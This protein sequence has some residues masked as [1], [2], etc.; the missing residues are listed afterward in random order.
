MRINIYRIISL[1]YYVIAA[2]I[3]MLYD[4]IMIGIQFREMD[5]CVFI[6]IKFSNYPV[7]CYYAEF[8]LNNNQLFQCSGNLHFITFSKSLSGTSSI[9]FIRCLTIAIG[10]SFR[11][12]I[13][14]GTPNVR[15]GSLS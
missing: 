10:S 14:N 3:L 13:K 9:S 12:F 7:V 2:K 4:T 11:I 1:R 15:V 6:V 5:H 8:V